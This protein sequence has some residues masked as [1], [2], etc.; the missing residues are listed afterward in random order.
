MTGV[1]IAFEGLDGSGKSTQVRRLVESLESAGVDTLAVREP[2]GTPAGEDIR[3]IMFGDEAKPL[4]P[5]TW[6]F[7]MNAARAQLVAT[8]IRPALADGKSVVADRYYFSTL[9]Y[10]SGGDELPEDLVSKLCRIATVDLEPQV[11]I[12]LDL[13]PEEVAFRKRRLVS[14]VL[15]S[16]PL[17]FHRRVSAAYQRMASGDSE[18]WLVFDA[19]LAEE[20]IAS[21][22]RQ[23]T[24]EL[25]GLFLG[26]AS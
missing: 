15:D 18:R 22:I 13:P 5:M 11:V 3:N 21:A 2:G 26:A 8:V 17:E 9:A 16:R 24:F 4:E 23:R 12:F 6:A 19:T 25:F 7:L 10:Q 20:E 14:N 1:F